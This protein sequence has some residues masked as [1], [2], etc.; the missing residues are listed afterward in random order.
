MSHAM[1]HMKES[2]RT[3]EWVMPRIWM[4]YSA[5]MNWSCRRYEYFVSREFDADSNILRVMSHI[6]MSHV[7][8]MN[9]SCHA[10]WR[11]ATHIN[12]SCHV[13]EPVMSHMWMHH[14]KLRAQNT[15]SHRTPSFVTHAKLATIE[16]LIS[17]S[18]DDVLAEW[19]EEI[20]RS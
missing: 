4:S 12:E 2:C 5:H 20:L 16:S 8:C 14:A 10:K 19:L 9:M 17:F 7:T 13:Y 1:S 3:Y 15:S 18:A 11:H 6:W